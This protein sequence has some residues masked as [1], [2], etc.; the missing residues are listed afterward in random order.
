LR[1]GK[2]E[3]NWKEKGL[4]EEREKVQEVFLPPKKG[5]APK[6]GRQGD[7]PDTKA[8]RERGDFAEGDP[9]E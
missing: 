6:G 3:E 2:L 8:W 1:G 5:G 7:L 4:K 9:P